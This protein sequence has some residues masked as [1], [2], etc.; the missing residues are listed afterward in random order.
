MEIVLTLLTGIA[1]GG[2]AVW[3]VVRD[4]AAIQLRGAEERFALAERANAELE[5]RFE[6]LSAEAL[7]ANN[8]AF[9]QLAGT[10]LDGY[11][12]PLKASLEKVDGQVRTLEQDRQRAFGALRQEL[13]S[14]HES[15]EKLRHETGNLV[16]ALRTPHIRGR[17]GEVQLK[18]VVEVAG[19]LPHCDFVVQA[20]VRDGEGALLRPDVV[21][22]LPGGKS[23]V[24]DAKVPLA[25]YLDACEATDDNLRDVALANHARQFRDH[26]GKLSA[27]S[28]WKQFDPAPDFVVMFLPDEG[29][30]RAAMEHDSSILEDA[31]R[32]G[33]VP[34]SP[35]TLLAL[36]RTVATGWRQETVA[37]SA[38]EVHALG[39]ELYER[40]GTMARHVQQ[41]GQSIKSAVGHYNK[42][43]GALE[44][45]VL[46][47]G[48]KLE[49]HGVVGDLPELEPIDL[50]PRALEAPELAERVEGG[51]R[52][53]DAA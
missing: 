17:W 30:L 20:S 2:A 16:T 40:L 53:L 33:V 25:A 52:A 35:N 9:L 7:R 49:A 47:T 42:T 46:V 34:A 13:T 43:V 50:Q 1:L 26:V 11:V 38:R 15:Q 27:K 21:V 8:T 28:Y 14:L 3:F 6:A 45:R 10:K 37:E 4:R 22:N 51:S 36:L 29:F 31:W 5:R 41:L 24:L 12:A 18:R 39:V 32:A 44:S 48:R 23:V 19:M